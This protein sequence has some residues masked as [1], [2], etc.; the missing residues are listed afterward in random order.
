MEHP[1]DLPQSSVDVDNS[2]GAHAH[3]TD[4]GLIDPAGKVFVG[5]LSW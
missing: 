3:G 2:G 4:V 5:G 1:T